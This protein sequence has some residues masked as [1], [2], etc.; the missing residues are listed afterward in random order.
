MS[1]HADLIRSSGDA[2]VRLGT[3]LAHA[4]DV[5]W[6]PPAAPSKRN[7]TPEKAKHTIS[8]PTVD[9]ALDERRLRVRAAVIEG[10]T[11]LEAIIEQAHDAATSLEAAFTEW[12]GVRA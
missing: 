2:L 11:T 9:T 5:Q 3:A 7:E 1:A 10:E 4:A 6:S 12:A 8:N